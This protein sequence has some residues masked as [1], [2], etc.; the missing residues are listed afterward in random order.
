[1]VRVLWDPLFCTL[2]SPDLFNYINN[3]GFISPFSQPDRTNKLLSVGRLSPAHKYRYQILS[4]ISQ[5]SEL[6]SAID[7]K[8]T[9]TFSEM[10]DL[11]SRYSFS[12]NA[13]LNLDFNR[14]LIESTIAGTICISDSLESLQF[15]GFFEIFN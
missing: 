11:L 4:N 12:F 7:H 6:T 10:I 1:M 13:S 9:T 5:D 14:R 15:S 8:N 2:L 3:H